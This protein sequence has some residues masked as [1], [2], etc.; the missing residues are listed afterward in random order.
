MTSLSSSLSSKL[1]SK[2]A[3]TKQKGFSLIELVVSIVVIGIAF[4]ALATSL[5]SSVGKSADVLWQS[6]STQ[7]SQAYL[8]EILAMRYQE[9]SPLGGGSVGSCTISGTDAGEGNRSL[10]DDV[11]DYDGLVETA[12]FLDTSITSNYSGYQ[13]SVDVSCLAANGSV[14]ASSKLIAVTVA[15]PTNQ[16]MVFSA[17]RADL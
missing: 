16:I 9:N 12:D 10:Y 13:V 17:F 3:L 4:G 5:F 15:S 6:K 7:L 14:S 2:H 8:D 11:D 1:S